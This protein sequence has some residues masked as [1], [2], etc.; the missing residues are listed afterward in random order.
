MSASFNDTRPST[1]GPTERPTDDRVCELFKPR[2]SESFAPAAPEPEQARE[3]AHQ[4]EARMLQ[5]SLATTGWNRT[6]A[7]KKL[8]MAVRTLSYRIEVLGV[9]KPQ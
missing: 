9:K 7:A 6:E 5:E 2:V 1:P 3:K 8:G 4:L